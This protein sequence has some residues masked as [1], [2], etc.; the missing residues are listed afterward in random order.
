MPDVDVFGCNIYRGKDGFG[1][2]F[3]SQVQRYAGKPVLITEFG[4]PAFH[5]QKPVDE[6][7]PL[8]AEYLIGNWMDIW[9]NRAGSGQGIALGGVAYEY[10]DEWWKAGP[11]PEFDAYQQDTVGDF[12]ADFPDGW[13]HEEWLGITSQGDGSKS[14]FMRQLRQS[15]FDLKDLWNQQQE[16][17]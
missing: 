14:P 4:C 13:M 15:Y 5:N 7:E 17:G 10:I 2:S 12:K 11:P 3:W 6:A 8:Q 16:V 1:K 9:N